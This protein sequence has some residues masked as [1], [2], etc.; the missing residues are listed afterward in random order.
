MGGSY[1]VEFR[2]TEGNVHTCHGTFREIVPGE[3]VSYTWSWA[4][5]DPIDTLVTW[6]VAAHGDRTDLVMTHVGFPAEEM[7][8][9]SGCSTTQPHFAT[10]RR[11]K[12][13]WF[14]RATPMA[15]RSDL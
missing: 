9:D 1:R 12:P 5:Q 10:F 6:T 14:C 2:T 11:A 7:R 3:K 15:A 13:T 8:C 4:E